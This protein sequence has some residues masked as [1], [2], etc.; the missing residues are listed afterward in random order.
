MFKPLSSHFFKKVRD[1]EDEESEPETRVG[2][3]QDNNEDR[4]YRGQQ[5]QLQNSLSGTL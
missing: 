3:K 1:F 4:S 5:Q 2:L